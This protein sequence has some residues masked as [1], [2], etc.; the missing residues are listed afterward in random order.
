MSE[1][2]S[3]I[4]L[5]DKLTIAGAMAAVAVVLA[6]LV[7]I[8]TFCTAD[9]HTHIYDYALQKNADGGFSVAGICTVENCEDP[10]Y[11]EKNVQG[12]NV[13][14]AVSPTC[15]KEGNIVYT[16][17]CNGVTL[18]LTE[19]LPITAHMYEYEK[20][21][22]GGKVLI[23]GMCKVDG[24]SN[25]YIFISD[26][27]D[28]T[29]ISVEE[30]TCFS[31]RKETYAFISEGV[32]KTFTTLVDE[33]IS[34]T[35]LS[36]KA[37]GFESADGT[38]PY[39]LEGVKI[40][41]NAIPCGGLGQGY[42][43]CE[44]CHQAV[45]INI[46]RPGHEFVANEESLVAP[47]LDADGRVSLACVNEGCTTV[48]ELTLPKVVK[49]VNAT[50]KSDATELHREV[51]T[52]TM[53]SNKY[54]FTFEKDYE[55]GELLEHDYKYT[56]EPDKAYPSRYNLIGTCSQPE[57]QQSSV[58]VLNVETEFVN[59]STCTQLGMWIWSHTLSNGEVV[60]FT[61]QSMTY[62]PHNCVESIVKEP[63]FTEEGSV[64]L[65]CTND[66]CS[67]TEVVTLPKADETNCE[68]Y[69]EDALYTTYI[70][71]YYVE[72]YKLTIST[73]VWKKK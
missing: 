50:T 32:E 12:V 73:V 11:S 61:V 48:E 44:V 21:D 15:V 24:C 25:P 13:L 9:R 43:V 1:I 66:N 31:P 47:T 4:R 29:L 40:L 35:L 58:I 55:I 56:L 62:A 72:E 26:A 7:G 49:G 27:R 14:S 23:S 63:S 68:L 10:Y 41:G 45:G 53:P 38:Y 36:V 33:N 3:S 57:C 5:K 28:L 34:H 67:F 8:L 71:T 65:T 54:G 6:T 30:G 51:I 52:Y 19:T 42:Y 20:T 59:T 16:Y 60:S 70:Y 37:N 46:R 2:F 39:G 22:N 17:N 64:K 18:K 69:K